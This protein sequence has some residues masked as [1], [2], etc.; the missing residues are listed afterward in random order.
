MEGERPG[1]ALPPDV[2]AMLEVALE[3][4]NAG[5]GVFELWLR[6]EEGHVRKFRLTREGGRDA[7]VDLDTGGQDGSVHEPP[8]DA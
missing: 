6:A 8:A 3:R 4:M 5:S 7:L 1:S 2:A